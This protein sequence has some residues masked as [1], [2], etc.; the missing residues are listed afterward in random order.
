MKQEPSERADVARNDTARRYEL[1]V[2]GHVAA[3]AQYE[4]DGDRVIL[5]HTEV[6]P[7]YEGQGLASKLAAYALDDVQQ[8][9]LKCVPQ[10]RF[11]AGY[12]ARHEDRY[13]ELVPR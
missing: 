13:G 1:R 11:M 3:V 10:C 2:D 5:T 12:I 8:R 6:E 7:E 4:Q 9:G